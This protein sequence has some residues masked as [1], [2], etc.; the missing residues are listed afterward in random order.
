MRKD[1]DSTFQVGDAGQTEKLLFRSLGKETNRNVAVIAST[2]MQGGNW[3][4][5]KEV[6]VPKYEITRKH[7]SF[8]S[9]LMKH[10]KAHLMF[11][12]YLW[13]E[14]SVVSFETC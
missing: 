6:G 11:H 10:F 3:C 2:I 7:L 9:F 4:F 12:I 5:A 1:V 8:A 13:W 14:G